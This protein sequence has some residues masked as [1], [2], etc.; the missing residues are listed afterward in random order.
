M[1]SVIDAE[2]NSSHGCVSLC[3]IQQA[4]QADTK[5]TQDD[6]V[7]Y[8]NTIHAQLQERKK[9]TLTRHLFHKSFFKRYSNQE[10]LQNTHLDTMRKR[11]IVCV[12]LW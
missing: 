5:Q 12:L 10:M 7:L 9:N 6:N 1:K 4:V 3:V 11:L 8:L 2:N